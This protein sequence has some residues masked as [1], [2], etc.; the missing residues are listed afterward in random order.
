MRRSSR[1]IITA[2]AVLVI[3]LTAVIGAASLPA[4]ADVP[5]N[6]TE[7]YQIYV[8]DFTSS[9]NAS[10]GQAMQDMGKL[11]EEKT[12][13]QVSAVTVAGL[14]GM[15]MD[16]YSAKLFQTWK[17][18]QAGKDNGVLWILAVVDREY[19]VRIGSAFQDTLTASRLERITDTALNDFRAGNYSRGMRIVYESLCKE[20]ASYY[21]VSLT[22]GGNTNTNYAGDP[23][24]STASG[25]FAW[26]GG[27]IVTIIVILILIV[28]LVSIF[29][30][31]RRVTHYHTDATHRR[32]W[33]GS[34]WGWM[35]LGS[36][37]N[38]N[39]HHHHHHGHNSH[40]PGFGGGP[41]PG[42]RPP[43]G[44]LGGG[45]GGG[46]HGGGFGGSF[47]GGGGGMGRGGHGGKF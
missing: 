13:A 33:G 43:S 17:L 45:F 8:N 21:G 20:V 6:P 16:A 3:M 24:G 35:F 10:D 46:S 19:Y 40:G 5:A 41:R 22:S 30:G 34:P 37:M 14:D 42:P 26:L 11:L 29:G 47:R 18:G 31:Q 7:E 4:L 32:G 23:G 44:G 36:M 38:N 9:I 39:R 27:A 12:G 28:V 1:F 25:A 2:R 15:T